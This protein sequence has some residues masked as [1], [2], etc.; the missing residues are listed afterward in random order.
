MR[1][2]LDDETKRK[3]KKQ[4]KIKSMCLKGKEKAHCARTG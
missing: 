2:R 4:S 1:R 3:K